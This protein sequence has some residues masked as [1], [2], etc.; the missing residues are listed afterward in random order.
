MAIEKNTIYNIDCLDGLEYIEDKTIDCIL[1][2]PPYNTTNC[3]WDL[4]LLNKKYSFISKN[5]Q[6]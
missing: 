1:T 6:K 2:D 5:I 3:K 4:N